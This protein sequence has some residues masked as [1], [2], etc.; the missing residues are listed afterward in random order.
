MKRTYTSRKYG[1]FPPLLITAITMNLFASETFCS[2]AQAA[3][4]SLQFDVEH[5]VACVDVQDQ[6]QFKTEKGERLV[7]ARI[8]ISTLV[9]HGSPDKLVQLLMRIEN[10]D[11]SIQVVDYQPRTTLAT[12]IVGN[13]G[14]ETKQDQAA[15]FDLT[16]SGQQAGIRGTTSADFGTK[17]GKSVKWQHLPPLELL[18]ASGTIARGSGAYFKL[19]SSRRTSLEGN[20][21]FTLLL[22]VPRDWQSGVL[23]IDCMG[24]ARQRSTLTQREETVTCGHHRFV[25]ALHATGNALAQRH[26]ERLIQADKALRQSAIVHEQQI[27]ARA[28]PYPGYRI[29]AFLQTVEPQIPDHWLETVLFHLPR[30]EEPLQENPFGNWA[31]L[32]APVHDAARQYLRAK[33][34]LQLANGLR[35]LVRF[36]STAARV[37]KVD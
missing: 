17:Q 4:P 36:S 5:R 2:L 30:S 10:P 8:P 20:R 19:K 16:L 29:A 33:R 11:R 6:S 15:A 1:F 14:I 12:D 23:H 3:L 32:P 27:L 25:V 22:R 34:Q 37:K 21:N 13:I 31:R 28:Y 7:Q 26:A 18:A 35:P 9:R 24:Q